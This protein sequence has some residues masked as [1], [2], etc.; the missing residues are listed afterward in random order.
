[1]GWRILGTVVVSLAVVRAGWAQTYPLS[2]TSQAGDCFRIHLDMTLSG[3]M[4]VNKEG[5]PVSLK[6]EATATHEF[7]ERILHVAADG[8]PEKAARTSARST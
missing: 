4:R 5:K 3:E 8:L 6:L 1:M 7:P 2:E